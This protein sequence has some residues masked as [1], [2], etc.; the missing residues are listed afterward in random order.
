MDHTRVKNVLEK[1]VVKIQ[2]VVGDKKLLTVKDQSFYESNLEKLQSTQGF[3]VPKSK[4]PA[5]KSKSLVKK[6]GDNLIKNESMAIK[7]KT[8]TRYQAAK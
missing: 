6:E 3:K 7:S 5:K 4:T 1:K 2:K 8:P